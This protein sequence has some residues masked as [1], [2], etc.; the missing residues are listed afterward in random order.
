MNPPQTP[1][2]QPE[3][4]EARRYFVHSRID[5]RHDYEMPCSAE[6]VDAIDYDTLRASHA[7]VSAQLAKAERER[8]QDRQFKADAIERQIKAMSER[9]AAQSQ[10]RALRER[11]RE[12][13]CTI[14][15]LCDVMIFA[16]NN[17]TAAL[18]DCA[19]W[20]SCDEPSVEGD[21]LR[22]RLDALLS[23]EVPK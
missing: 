15:R 10:V 3:A 23:A 6:M 8:A 4:G 20:L 17:L 22:K 18:K 16:H 7:E 13:N 11:V 12:A 1:Q 19:E 2:N 14:N 9:D 21:A 5:R